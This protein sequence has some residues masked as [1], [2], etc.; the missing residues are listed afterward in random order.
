MFRRE[1]HFRN[2]VKFIF[3]FTLEKFH[4]EENHY[5]THFDDFTLHIKILLFL[6]ICNVVYIN[7]PLKYRQT[8]E[9]CLLRQMYTATTC[10]YEASLEQSN[11]LLKN[12]LISK[13]VLFNF[14]SIIIYRNIN[15]K[16]HVLF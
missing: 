13:L 3:L 15:E 1:I 11:I 12:T 14:D 2:I 16:L 4:L 6:N 5:Y 10:N 7:R 9:G 8:D